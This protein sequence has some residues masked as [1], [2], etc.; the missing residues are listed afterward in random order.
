MIIVIEIK[1]HSAITI[2]DSTLSHSFMVD[3]SPSIYIYILKFIVNTKKKHTQGL[4]RIALVLL[5]SNICDIRWIFQP[6]ALDFIAKVE[7]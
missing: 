7:S 5:F 6:T 3:G 4:L 1:F 2:L